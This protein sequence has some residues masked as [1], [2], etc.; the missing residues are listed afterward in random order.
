MKKIS[1]AIFS[2]QHP[3]PS[4]GAWGRLCL[5]LVFLVLSV[6]PSSAQIKFGI[7][8]GLDVTHMSLSRKVF[9]NE[10]QLGFYIGPTVKLTLLDTGFGLDAAALYDQRSADIDL[11]YGSEQITRNEFAVNQKQIA[12]PINIRYAIGIGDAA[13]VFF[14]AGPQFGFNVGSNKD[15]I[16]WKWR[17]SNF[18]FNLGAG[19]TVLSHLQLNVNYNIVCGKTGELKASER[20]RDVDGNVRSRYNAWQIGMAY[21]F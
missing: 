10:N 9:D 18:S 17:D 2:N 3:F 16:N 13:N 21:Y 12:V 19:F 1:G 6:F 7:K 5:S 14:F 8:G 4:K 20:V 11:N 15:E